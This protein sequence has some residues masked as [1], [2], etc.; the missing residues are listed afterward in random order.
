MPRSV[1]ARESSITVRRKQVIE[2]LGSARTPEIVN[3]YMDGKW[4]QSLDRRLSN[5]LARSCRELP[6]EELAVL[7]CLSKRLKELD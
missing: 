3:A 2:S 5:G 4:L 7:A 6:R 1:V